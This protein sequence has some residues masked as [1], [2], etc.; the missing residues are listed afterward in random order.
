M[1]RLFVFVNAI[2]Q[3]LAFSSRSIVLNSSSPDPSSPGRRSLVI[4]SVGGGVFGGW[5]GRS[6][7]AGV[8]SSSPRGRSPKGVV[9]PTNEVVEVVNGMKRRRLG[10]S[11]ILVSEL[12][13]GTQRWYVKVRCL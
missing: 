12:G 8:A 11:D 5:L 2:L 4:S 3:S 10:G 9:G 1:I 13:L 6:G 7:A